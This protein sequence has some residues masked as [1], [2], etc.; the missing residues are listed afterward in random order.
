MTTHENNKHLVNQR[1]RKEALLADRSNYSRLVCIDAQGSLTYRPFNDQGDCIPDFSCVGYKGGSEPIPDDIPALARLSPS[2][3][4]ADDTS[5]IQEVIDDISRRHP[6]ENGFRGAIVLE[7]GT[8]RISRTLNIR[9]SGIV[10]RG[11][12]QGKGTQIIANVN[13]WENQF[14]VVFRGKPHERV[15]NTQAEILGRVP[16]GARVLSV[17]KMRYRVG[18]QVVVTITTNKHWVSTIGM[19][20]IPTK[21]SNV[22]QWSPMR[23]EAFRTLIGIDPTHGTIT[24]DAPL[25]MAID[26]EFGGG[27]VQLV[28]SSRLSHVGIEDIHFLCPINEG[29]RKEDLKEIPKERNGDYRFASEMFLNYV[30]RFE[31]VENAW[32]KGVNSTWFHNHISIGI[33]SKNLTLQGCHHYYPNGLAFYSGQSCYQLDGQLCLLTDCHSDNSF[34]NFVYMGRV[35]GPNV[36]HRCSATGPGDSGPHMRWSTGQLY[37]CCKFDGTL[38]IQDRKDMG[39]GHGWSGANCV[40]WNCTV[41]NGIIVQKPP[42]AQNFA[43]GSTDRFAK[44]VVPSHERGWWELA[45]VNVSPQSLYEAQLRN[46]K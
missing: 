38:L 21:K 1:Y 11:T 28:K 35:P 18:D 24:L 25:T 43:I 42:T 2:S 10:I 27:H 19:D 45:G 17:K 6:L 3:E 32:A 39:T 23:F 14:L 44:P 40:V 36:V 37:D 33:G 26:P 12:A 16:V 4:D 34:H 7:E 46:R 31:H 30:L 9:A 15:S 5:R 22:K 13:P 41:K 20:R 29:R 8:F